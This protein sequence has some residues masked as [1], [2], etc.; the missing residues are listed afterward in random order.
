M[1]H[2]DLIMVR[3]KEAIRILE[4]RGSYEYMEYRDGFHAYCG[5]YSGS[6]VGIFA[7]CRADY[8]VKI[9][10]CYQKEFQEEINSL[11]EQ[12]KRYN[13]EVQ[14]FEILEKIFQYP[15]ATE[16][17]IWYYTE[18][19]KIQQQSHGS[20]TQEDR[21][22]LKDEE[23]RREDEFALQNPSYGKLLKKYRELTNS[24]QNGPGFDSNQDGF[25]V[26][27]MEGIK[28]ELYIMNNWYIRDYRKY[29]KLFARLAE[30]EPYFYFGEI[31][32]K[33]NHLHEVASVSLRELHVGH[34]AFLKE[35]DVLRINCR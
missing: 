26:D 22:K 35:D 10:E 3:D 4:E 28:E 1:S 6:C 32:T 2:F 30:Y 29:C 20:P 5:N 31:F 9:A 25:Y 7:A 8:P 11:W 21:K 13:Y 16:N 34:F 12:K 18:F 17:T 14:R 33:P 15:F 23:K 27:S 19:E 24:N